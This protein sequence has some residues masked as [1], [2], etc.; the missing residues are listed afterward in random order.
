MGAEL[1]LRADGLA[2]ELASKNTSDESLTTEISTGISLV[3]SEAADSVYAAPAEESGGAALDESPKARLARLLTPEQLTHL[4]QSTVMVL[5]LG[6]VGSNCVEALARGGIG[7]FILV[8]ADTVQPSNINR[9]AI[10]FTSTVG[11]PK[12]AVMSDMVLNIN[13]DAEIK[14]FQYF[15]TRENV[16]AFLQEHGNKV[17]FVVDAIDSIS[18]KLVIAQYFDNLAKTETNNLVPQLISSMGGG[19]KLDPEKFTFADLYDTVNCPLCRIMRKEG[20]KRGISQL[21]VLYSSEIPAESFTT[22]GATRKQ[23]SGLGTMSYIPPIMGQ[24]LA[25]YVIQNI[26]Q[27][28]G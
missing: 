22:E 13:P 23:R 25:G 2:A 4:E 26:T 27:I 17:D 20:R 21:Q 15:L 5:G 28:G 10:A 14:G 8:D 16:V 11:R 7:H 19:N 6:G 3:V 18:T 1:F 24:M 9:Q 12:V